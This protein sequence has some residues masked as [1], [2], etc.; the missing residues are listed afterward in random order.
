[1]AGVEQIQLVDTWQRNEVRRAI[2]KAV[3]H[4]GPAVVIAQGPC[5][6][7]PEMKYRDFVPYF[8]EEEI[9]TKCD[10]CFKVFCPAIK[11]TADGFPFIA[12][13]ECTACTVCAQV[14]PEDAIYLRENLIQVEG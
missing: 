10:A 4:Q 3:A 9:C 8:V 2:S 5:Q 13:A 12:A 14:C 6:Q 7:L 11:R 1:A